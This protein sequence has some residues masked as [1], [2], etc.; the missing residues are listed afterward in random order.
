MKGDFTRS[1]RDGRKHYSGVLHQ[2]GRVWLDSD[3]NEEGFERRRI[4]EQ[5]TVDII[6]VC[7]VPEPGI[8]FQISPNPAVPPNA[9]GDFLI[10]GGSGNKGHAYVDGILCEIDAPTSYLTQPDLLDP[11]PIVMPTDGSDLNA[12]VYLEVWHRLITY[13]EDSSIREVALGGPDTT[14]RIKTI[15][16]VKVVVIPGSTKD[17]TCPSVAMLLPAAGNG[18]LTTLAAPPPTPTDLCRLPDPGNYTGRENRLYRVEIHTAGG[19]NGSQAPARFKWSRNNA[20][21]AVAVTALSADRQTLTVS[22]LGRDQVTALRQGD[23][24]EICDDA[25]E[26]GPARGHLTQLSSDPD[27]DQLTVTISDPLPLTF[28]D[29]AAGG[30]VTSPPS[31]PSSPPQSPAVFRHMILRRWD[32]AG[33]PAAQFDAVATPDMDLGDG[34]HIQFGGSDLRSGDFWQFTAR[35]DGSLE[36]LTNESP[37]GILRHR[38]SLA[39]VKWSRP[40]VSPPSSPATVTGPYAMTVLHDC[41]VVF[42]PLAERAIH[43]TDITAIDRKQNRASLLNDSLIQTASLFGGIDITTDSDVVPPALSRAVCNVTVEI[44]IQLPNATGSDNQGVIVYVPISV[45]GDTTAAGTTISWRPR[46]GDVFSQMPFSLLPKFDKGMLARLTL[47]GNFVWSPQNPSVFLDGDVFGQNLAGLTSLRLPSGDGRRGGTFETWFW[48]AAPAVPP[49]LTFTL[50][51]T[52]PQLGRSAGITEL[53]G[54]L[55]LVGTGGNPTAAGSPVPPMNI[56]VVFNNAVTSRSAGQGIETVLRIDEPTTLNV[57]GFIQPGTI[58]GVGGDGV[59]YQSGAVPNVFGAHIGQSQNTVLFAVPIDPPGFGT[60]TLRISNFRLNVSASSLAGTAPAGITALVTINN[61]TLSANLGSAQAAISLFELTNPDN[62][63]P[64]PPLRVTNA[65][66]NNDP[67]NARINLNIHAR[68]GFAGAFKSLQQE[69]PLFVNSGLGIGVVTQGTQFEATFN[70]NS[71][72]GIVTIFVTMVDIDGGENLKLIS[73]NGVPNPTAGG[74]TTTGVPI[75]LVPIKVNGVGTAIARWEWV[76]T[77]APTSVRD[78]RVGVA[79]FGS[80]AAGTIT[81]T[82]QVQARIQPVNATTS[83]TPDVPL[84]RFVDQPFASSF[85]IAAQ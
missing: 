31:P 24:V 54:D 72:P 62:T 58:T 45:Q 55:V 12:L 22:S 7:G 32:G 14:T 80:V 29:P 81:P 50:A 13:L 57:S 78:L 59:S 85:V 9:P 56:Q 69:M 63:V 76:G 21:F 34:V 35:T 44:P 36:A 3:W 64:P 33:T 28:Q 83:S 49:P 67:Q 2:Q 77:T 74:K 27:P 66:M 61:Q 20:S 46:T 10:N 65:Q 47:K 19:L 41:R 8:A 1:I 38:C 71:S 68:E 15:A 30:A 51:T 23:L 5:E 84:P 37:R 79:L 18:T 82:V 39:V 75:A 43:V 40:V 42:P 25:S 11:P 52:T 16:Q 6:G 48:L 60:R 4:L 53:V 17:L 26:L 73:V 70:F